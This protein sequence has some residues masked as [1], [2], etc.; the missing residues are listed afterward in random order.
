M[1]NVLLIIKWGIK[2]STVGIIKRKK[3]KAN[4]SNVCDSLCAIAIQT[5]DPK[6]L[7]ITEVNA[8]DTEDK[9]VVQIEQKSS[10]NQAHGMLIMALQNTC[11]IAIKV[12]SM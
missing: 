11:V 1:I 10:E 7:K 12:F 4:Q 3:P 6:E 5:N 2:V 8:C 9:D